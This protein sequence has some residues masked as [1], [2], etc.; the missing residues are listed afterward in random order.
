MEEFEQQ[1]I[2]VSLPSLRLDYNVFLSFRGSTRENIR[3]NLYDALD[4]GIRVFRDFEGL[5][6]GDQIWQIFLTNIPNI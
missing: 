4:K 3:K 5:T 1:K 2:S 6:Q